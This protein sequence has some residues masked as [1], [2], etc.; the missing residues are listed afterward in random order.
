MLTFFGILAKFIGLF[1]R[2]P[3][4]N[5][6]GAKG[7]GVYQMIFPVYA[8]LVSVT[9]TAVPVLVS[10]NLNTIENER[11]KKGFFTATFFHAIEI[12]I[13]FGILLALSA[14]LL[15]L[16][17]GNQDVE[18]GYYI[19]A[20]AVFF[21]SVLASFR[22]WFNSNLK[23]FHTALTGVFEQFF[24]LSGVLV[25]YLTDASGFK[26]VSLALGGI[27]LAEFV[28]CLYSFIVFFV[29]G[30]RFEL[31]IIK[32]PI[33]DFLSASVPLTVGGLVFPLCLFADSILVIR[34]LKLAG[35]DN[36]AS[37]IEY[38]IFS[39]AVGTLV[40]VPTTLAIS[41]AVTMIPVVAKNKRERNIKGIKEG[42]SSALKAILFVALPCMTALFVV[43]EPIMGLL[44]PSFSAFERAR[45]V[46]LLRLS[47]IQI[48]IVSV[49]QLYGAY[50]QA[51]DKSVLSARNMLI[52]GAVKL[53]L[54]FTSIRLGIEGIILANT[55][56]Y[57]V[58]AVLDVY[59]SRA[60]SGKNQFKGVWIFVLSS[61]VMGVAMWLI[62]N[63]ISNNILSFVISLLIGALVYVI[64]LLVYSKIKN[65]KNAIKHAEDL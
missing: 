55:A 25:A 26:A 30:G 64:I 46:Y 54:N 45:A 41:F 2:I 34:L 50:L 24:K 14:K 37:V 27:V 39:G 1:Y 29:K 7:I 42:E 52:A 20:P 6:L 23:T 28:A 13:F 22:G 15:S 36:G 56:C 63:K 65:R 48:P 3:L 62:F 5:I 49:L 33:K 43:A 31:G 53:V 16:L 51:L 58:C 9:S 17:Q 44:Y 12:G 40:N 47:V 19:I 38:G 57:I 32:I 59:H 60:L 8:L 10:R 61:L 35:L 21:T 11:L 4:T 18:I